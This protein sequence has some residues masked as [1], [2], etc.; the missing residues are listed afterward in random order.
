MRIASVTEVI[1]GKLTNYPVVTSFNNVAFEAKR[2]ARGDLIFLQDAKESDLAIANGAYAVVSESQL[3]VKNSE[4]AYIKVESLD[5]AIIRYL[6][7]FASSKEADIFVADCVAVEFAKAYIKDRR[8]IAS[9]DPKAIILALQSSDISS[10]L[11]IDKAL[12][13]VQINSVELD[14]KPLNI[15]GKHICNTTVAD[16]L[17]TLQISSIFIDQLQFVYSLAKHYAL[18]LQFH[19]RDIEL[20]NFNCVKYN[21]KVLLF[22]RGDLFE[23]V[24]D[25]LQTNAP[26]AKVVSFD[27]VALD[28]IVRSIKY[29]Y[30]QY[31]YLRNIDKD[32][33]LQ[34]LESIEELTLF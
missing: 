4:I 22:D 12:E 8:L 1:R 27:G 20:D 15:V 2:V 5:D 17:T 31:G 28:L 7:L 18:N 6:R 26:W 11:L 24:I 19:S 13:A 9:T 30:F 23:N 21:D 29:D 34:K 25:F 16:P 3:E 10:I 14:T 32:S 33:L